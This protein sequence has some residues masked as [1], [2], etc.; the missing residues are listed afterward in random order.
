MPTAAQRTAQSPQLYLNR[1]LSW[2]DFNARVLHEALDARTPL[3]ERVKFLAIFSTNLDEFFMV[4]V[5]GLRRQ[6]AAGVTQPS[7]D[8]LTAQ[9]QLDAIA[10]QLTP[11][12]ESQQ[13][14]LA[15]LL[16]QLATHDIRLRS[17]SELSPAEFATL[18][19][20]FE[21]EVFPVLTP[22]AVD[23]G[24]PFPYISNLTLSLAVELRDPETGAEHFARVKV[25]RSLPRWV[26]VA[27]RAHHFVPLEQVIG[28]NLGALFPGYEVVR[29][30]VFRLTR[31]S[32]LEIPTA[33]E[34]E[35][36]LAMIE[37]QVFQRRFGEVVRLEI[38]TGTPAPV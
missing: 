17:V 22:L 18:D 6:L 36:L 3:L 2:L 35:D 10:Q 23:P 19:E 20:Y 28:A 29:S 24:H 33:E 15:E 14:C 27:G 13:A 1:E 16:E 8:G 9:E 32:D 26:R 30:F 38:E 25:P 11:L 4:R 12:L 37:E 7:P 5:A 34:P 31:Y 21:R